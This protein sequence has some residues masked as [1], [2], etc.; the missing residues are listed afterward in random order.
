VFKATLSIKTGR[1][2]LQVIKTGSSRPMVV[3]DTLGDRYVVK[4]RE[5]LSNPNASVSDFICCKL[6]LALGLPVVDPVWMLLE[7]GIDWRN[8][9]DEMQDTIAKSFG[10]NIAYP[11]FENAVDVKPAEIMPGEPP[12]LDLLIFDLLLLN[13]DRTLYN[14]NLI[15]IKDGHLYSFD[16]ETSMLV[17]GCLQGK[18]FHEHPGVLQQIRQSPLYFPDVDP[19][20]LLA[21]QAQLAQIDIAALLAL[22]PPAWLPQ[23]AEQVTLLQARL[24]RDWQDETRYLP[25]LEQLPALTAESEEARKARMMKNREA[26]E[27]RFRR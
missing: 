22:F 17:T 9:D 20:R 14:I 12:W 16:Y 11:F 24:S 6:G 1:R 10:Y 5:S 21:M 27:A 19:E 18:S 26:F 7:P 8:V 2:V 3:E 25:L 13:I 4:M 23:W 15:R